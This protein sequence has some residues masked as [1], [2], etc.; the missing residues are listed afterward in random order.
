MTVADVSSAIQ[1]IEQ[2]IASISPSAAQVFGTPSTTSS[3]ATPA[4]FATQLQTAGV[5]QTGTAATTLPD[6]VPSTTTP[7]VTPTATTATTSLPAPSNTQYD[8]LI[9]QAARDQ[10]VDPALL[11]GLVQAESGFNPSSVSSVGAQGLTQLM[12]DTAK[13]LGVS[14][15]FDPL[16]N[17]EGG[18]RFLA[19][20]LKRFG[21]NEQLALAA[22]NAGPGAV[23]R[24]GGIPPYAETQAY[25]PRVLDYANQYRAQGF[26]QTPTTAPANPGVVAPAAAPSGMTLTAAV[27][28]AP[29]A[30]AQHAIAV[31]SQFIGT[32]YHFGGA[33]PA[34]GFDCSGLAQYA[35][36]QS[37]VTLPR[38]A[39]DQY[40]VGQPVDRASLA[41]GDL[42]FFQDSTGYI[43]HEGIYLG[44][45]QF[46]QAPHTGDVVKIS[47]LDDPYY[48]GQFAGGR[49]MA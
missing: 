29:S 46:L 48:A 13:G 49:R 26:G 7:P 9:Q 33:S 23:E 14:N 40:K 22:Y 8:S 36:G 35:Y 19:G 16:Q 34:T 41:P 43:P 32:A 24:Y 17:L 25:V 44:N 39:A 12:P 28:A 1:V 21:N 27:G 15:P 11:K 45:D 30:T 37:G 47:S 31:A 6:L 38:V 10:G 3:A 18:A 20:A 5:D 4:S 2:R 42:V